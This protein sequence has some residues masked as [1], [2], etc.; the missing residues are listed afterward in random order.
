MPKHSFMLYAFLHLWFWAEFPVGLPE[1][2]YDTL[3]YN[4]FVLLWFLVNKIVYIVLSVCALP[5]NLLLGLLGLLHLYHIIKSPRSGVT[6]CFQFVSAAA[7]ASATATTFTSHIKIVWAK[8][9]IFG[10][11]N[12]WVL[13]NVLDD[14]SMTLTQGHGCG[15]N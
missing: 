5:F 9:Y 15:I 11:K 2:K 4:S 10:T 12:I 1:I 6:L 7:A 14:L 3:A 8:P 13:G